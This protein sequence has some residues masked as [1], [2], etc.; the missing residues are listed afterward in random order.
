VKPSEFKQRVHDSH[1][2]RITLLKHGAITTCPLG[3]QS[4]QVEARAIGTIHF[5]PHRQDHPN[6]ALCYWS[7]R[8]IP[9]E[10]DGQALSITLL[11]KK[12]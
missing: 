2:V 5:G 11:T 4:V 8:E 1:V 7:G 6:S 9:D 3:C 12:E 10:L